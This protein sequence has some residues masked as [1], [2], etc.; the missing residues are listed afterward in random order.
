MGV[1]VVQC[2]IFDNQSHECSGE[3]QAE[4]VLEAEGVLFFVF[5]WMHL[6]LSNVVENGCNDELVDEDDGEDE[7][8]N[9]DQCREV[10]LVG[11]RLACASLIRVLKHGSFELQ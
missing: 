5:G 9:N 3:E 11:R 7:A 2:C 8:I 4:C 1:Y 6:V 10:Q